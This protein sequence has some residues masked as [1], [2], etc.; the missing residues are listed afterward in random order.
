[1]N[2]D[3]AEEI[4]IARAEDSIV[5]HAYIGIEVVECDVSAAFASRMDPLAM[6]VLDA[7]SKT[8][9][10]KTLDEV[11]GCIGVVEGERFGREIAEVLFGLSAAGLLRTIRDESSEVRFLHRD[12]LPVE[13]R[14]LYDVNASLSYLPGARQLAWK[15]PAMPRRKVR[16]FASGVAS[17]WFCEGARGLEANVVREEIAKRAALFLLRAGGDVEDGVTARNEELQRRRLMELMKPYGAVVRR[18]HWTGLWNVHRCYIIEQEWRNQRGWRV[19]VLRLNSGYRVDEY[20]RFI[21]RL[22]WEEPALFAKLLASSVL[23]DK[24]S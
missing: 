23:V 2:G 15:I 20:S 12:G 1:M 4:M 21:E 8:K 7:L 14:I 5:R 6:C 16:K 17:I 11:I 9:I 18:A 3:Y 13:P 10:P 22:Q 19:G 24:R